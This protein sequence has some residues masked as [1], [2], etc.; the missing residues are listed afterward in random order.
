MTRVGGIDVQLLRTPGLGEVFNCVLSRHQC[1][2]EEGVHRFEQRWRSV[3]ADEAL[4]L[5]LAPSECPAVSIA[6]HPTQRVLAFGSSNGSVFFF[7]FSLKKWR[8]EC[9]QTS[10]QKEISCVSFNP[11]LP[12]LLA[13]GSRNFLFIWDMSQDG[14][15]AF[16]SRIQFPED[17]VEIEFCDHG[18]FL[19][20]QLTRSVFVLDVATCHFPNPDSIPLSV[21]GSGSI[22]NVRWS[23]SS[24]F[25]AVSRSNSTGISLFETKDWS[26]Y[27]FHF[28]GRS[29]S[30]FLTGL[31][32][33][34]F[35]STE[36]LFASR[37]ADDCVYAV[38]V[39]DNMSFRTKSLALDPHRVVYSEPIIRLAPSTSLN[40]M[41][42]ETRFVDS[43]GKIAISPRGDRLAVSFDKDGRSAVA[44]FAMRVEVE[45][46]APVARH[47]GFIHRPSES[48]E[49]KFRV[50]T[51]EFHRHIE[52]GYLLSILWEDGIVS[53]HPGIIDP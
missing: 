3:L 39:P 22:S 30:W 48:E 29:K 5:S 34:S 16:R 27:P 43:A 37:N 49:D 11:V 35:K 23:P 1:L 20:V 6:W 42:Q 12:S 8:K 31:T 13:A 28:P 33:S 14:S 53:L 46:S 50:L 44:I 7:D 18:R 26:S 45:L 51:M 10:E 38:G 4:E 32:W 9:L 24:S 25:L 47:V 52:I 40:G 21:P 41:N 2:H 36:I 17:V 19:A 15:D